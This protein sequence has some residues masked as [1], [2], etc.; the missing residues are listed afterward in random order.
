MD[1]SRMRALPQ[2][3]TDGA[4]E[5]KG[6]VFTFDRV[7]Q[8]KIVQAMLVD[9]LWA[10]QFAEVLNID[11]FQ[12]AYLKLVASKYLDYYEKYREFPSMELLLN[13][14][15][16]DLSHNKDTVL[17]DQIK[18]FLHR[19]ESNQDLGDLS[20]VKDKSLEFCRKAGLHKAFEESV[21]LLDT[22]KYEHIVDIIKKAISAGN[23]NTPGLNLFNDIDARYSE[24]YRR[25]IGTGIPILDDRKILNGG[26]GG[27]E[28]G[29]VIAPTGVGKTHVL[30]HL[31]AAALRQ[32]KNVLHYSYEIS[33]RAT[34]I[35]Y[36]SNML[37]IDS[38]ECYEHKEDI[39]KF[40]EE[41]KENLGQLRVKY[42]PTG[43]ATVNTLRS[44]MDKLAMTENFRPDMIIIDYAGIMRSTEKYELL[45]Q[46]L[47]RVFEDLRT[48]AN[49]CDVPVWTAVQSNKDGAD[50]EYVDLTNMAESYGQAHVAD[51]VLG[52]NRRSANKSTGYGNIFVAKNRNGIDGLQYYVHLDT[53][54]STLRVLTDDEVTQMKSQ[55]DIDAS[56]ADNGID[57][58]TLSFLRKRFK[59]ISRRDK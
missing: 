55:A 50:K 28:L 54:R 24:T 10:G 52:L 21:E 23:V 40:Y 5:S 31:G 9:R 46:E 34:C 26:L 30:V 48:F 43:T 49:E 16:E 7:F 51:F 45:R 39:R 36:D 42:Y 18:A 53:A 3:T 12:F 29:V 27:G 33:E 20:Y 14:L 22:E 15:V 37:Q 25:T 8:E 35:R 1:A 11:F 57:N 17:R 41:N 2:P 4:K 59:D 32:G 19:V 13:I 47:K 44:H 56:D 58:G 6:K 38:I